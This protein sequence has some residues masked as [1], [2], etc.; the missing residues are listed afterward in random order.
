MHKNRAE[1]VLELLGIKAD[2]EKMETSDFKGGQHSSHVSADNIH[3]PYFNR[4]N[5]SG[6]LDKSYKEMRPTHIKVAETEGQSGNNS[7]RV[8]SGIGALKENRKRKTSPQKFVYND[9]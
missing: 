5:V 1:S 3:S 9:D 7:S 4:S 2:G 6:N 8:I